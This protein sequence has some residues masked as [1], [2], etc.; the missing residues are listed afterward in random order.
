[1]S[2]ATEADFTRFVYDEIR[3]Q[4]ESC[5]KMRSRDELEGRQQIIGM[6]QSIIVGT[7]D[8]LSIRTC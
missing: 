3:E 5:V 4:D 2:R 1:M 8:L 6:K 7:I